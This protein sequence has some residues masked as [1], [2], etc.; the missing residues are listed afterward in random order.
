MMTESITREAWLHKAVEIFRARFI[1]VGHPL[2]EK[3]HVSVGFGKGARSE[4]KNVRGVCWPR[5]YSL[6]GVNHIFISPCLGDGGENGVAQVLLTL[7]HELI[8]AADDCESGHRGTFAEIATRFGFEGKKTSSQASIQLAAELMVLAEELGPYPHGVL[9]PTPVRTAV[10]PGGATVVPGP[11][12]IPTQTTRY[13]K[14]ICPGHIG[15]QPCGYAIR[16]TRVHA[17]RGLPICPCGTTME[18]A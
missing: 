12:G 18:L 15:D 3:L 14:A 5:A 7:L 9:D 6:D 13:L 8:H 11:S 2:P 1:E 17:A 4:S 16:I 10:G